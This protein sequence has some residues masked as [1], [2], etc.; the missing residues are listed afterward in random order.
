M[1]VNDLYPSRYVRA[2]DLNGRRVTVTIKH[3]AVER[4]GQDGEAKPV[5]YFK[6]ATKGLVL[7][8]TNALVIAALYG[9]ETDAWAGKAITLYPTQVRAFGATHDCI[10]V[11]QTQAVPGGLDAGQ[12]VTEQ[13][14]AVDDV[15]D[16]TDNP[17]D[18]EAA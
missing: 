12:T 5:V 8:R 11:A 17:F 3:V 7:N 15:D 4:M 2:A 18:D 9:P 6:N 10:R 16:L 13:T 14:P 1:N